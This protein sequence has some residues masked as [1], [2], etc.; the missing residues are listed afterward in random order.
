MRNRLDEMDELAG[1]IIAFVLI[2]MLSAL[3]AYI[4]G[5]IKLAYIEHMEEKQEVRGEA[6]GARH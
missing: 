1:V 4:K 3:W 6:L 5:P 2:I